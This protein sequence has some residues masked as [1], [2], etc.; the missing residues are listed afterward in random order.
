MLFYFCFR[1]Q[2]EIVMFDIHKTPFTQFYVFAAT[3][4]DRY[5]C[6]RRKTTFLLFD[7]M[8][9]DGCV[10]H[11]VLEKPWERFAMNKEEEWSIE[12][13]TAVNLHETRNEFGI[14]ESSCP[15]AN[16]MRIILM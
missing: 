1:A 5:V 4:I 7:Y 16:W 8:H 10:L 3:S 15:E 6:N 13:C 14:D 11:N 9:I 12:Y 2:H